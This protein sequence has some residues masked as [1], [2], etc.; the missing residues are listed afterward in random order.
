[1]RPRKLLRTCS[2]HFNSCLSSSGIKTLFKRI[3]SR[4]KSSH[5]LLSG[6]T[7][8]RK[9]FPNRRSL[10]LT[11]CLLRR[12]DTA[13]LLRSERRGRRSKGSSKSRRR[14]TSSSKR[15]RRWEEP[16]DRGLNLSK[17]APKQI[18]PTSKAYSTATKRSLNQLPQRTPQMTFTKTQGSQKQIL[19][20]TLDSPCALPR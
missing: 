12:R 10:S 9:R 3:W 14:E 19:R 20:S 4:L 5:P 6:R 15:S 8:S 16:H 2:W 7:L 11:Q 13:L 18:T 17:I 1:M